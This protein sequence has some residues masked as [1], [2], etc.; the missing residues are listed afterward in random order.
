MGHSDR[1]I[2]AQIAD[3]MC[4]RKIVPEWL[5]MGTKTLL[6]NWQQDIHV[7]LGHYSRFIYP[8]TKNTGETE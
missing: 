1:D 3:R 7:T 2:G 8:F 5:Q 6:E 4:I